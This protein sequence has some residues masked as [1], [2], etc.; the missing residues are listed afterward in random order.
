MSGLFDQMPASAA[1]LLAG[2]ALG[3]ALTY[4]VNVMLQ[5][6][7]EKIKVILDLEIK[8]RSLSHLGAWAVI[9]NLSKVPIWVERLTFQAEEFSDRG[10]LVPLDVGLTIDAGKDDRLECHESIYDAFEQITRRCDVHVGE[11]EVTAHL[12]PNGKVIKK[13]RAY[14]L[15]SSR[16]G[17][18]D[19]TEAPSRIRRLLKRLRVRYLFWRLGGS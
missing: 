3:A 16:Y 11:I 7:Q 12:R 14:H 19:V 10:K 8:R 15:T 2:V 18:Q 5:R 1:Q 17:V 13:R 6:R 4:F 9:A